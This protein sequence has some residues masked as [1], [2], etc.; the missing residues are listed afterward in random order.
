MQS[1]VDEVIRKVLRISF[2]ERFMDYFIQVREYHK[3]YKEQ[4]IHTRDV[5]IVAHGH[6]SRVLIS[7]WINF[8]LCLGIDYSHAF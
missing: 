4:G 2:T 6:F 3:E 8:P 1:R 5:L 7:R